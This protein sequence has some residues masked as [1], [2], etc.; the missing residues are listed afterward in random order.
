MKTN[1]VSHFEIYADDS[2]KL[3]QFYT[4]LFDWSFESVPGMDYA[5][6]KT[7]ESG[8]KGPT[9]PGGIN[10]GMIA[11][12]AG[13]TDRAWV[14][15]VNVDSLDASSSKAQSLGAKVMKGKT[16]VPGMG[17]FAILTDPQGNIFA[18]WQNDP[19]AK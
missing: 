4:S 6:I 17:W 12:P 15:Y 9:Q 16:A 11:R 5:F 13:Y 2:A 18:I 10:G 19:G 14:N 7:V 3:Q 1:T 8:D